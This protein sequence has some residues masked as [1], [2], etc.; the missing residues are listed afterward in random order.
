MLDG[1]P[2]EMLESALAITTEC[3]HCYYDRMRL[4]IL[5]SQQDM[6]KTPTTLGG[7]LRGLAFDIRTA[8][9]A[10]IRGLASSTTQ[11]VRV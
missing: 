8:P 5:S 7:R 3:T 9:R 4:E 6:P 10:T 2:V 11:N 1:M